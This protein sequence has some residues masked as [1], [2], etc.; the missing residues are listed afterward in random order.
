MSPSPLSP[1]G[2]YRCIEASVS[3]VYHVLQN[4]SEDETAERDRL[5][6]KDKDLTLYDQVAEERAYQV[7]T[8]ARPNATLLVFGATKEGAAW[9]LPTQQCVDK[10]SRFLAGKKSCEW[11][12][13]WCWH[14]S[15]D[16]GM[17]M[18]GVTAEA[19]RVIEW[20]KRSMGATFLGPPTPTAVN[21]ALALPFYF[22][23]P[24]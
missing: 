7:I 8:V 18:N 1:C 4:L 21:G 16:K 5:G 6:L 22:H 9:L 20:L 13:S 15:P 19:T 10:H 3:S 17:L 12:L 11:I 24:T 23:R 14:L 2:K